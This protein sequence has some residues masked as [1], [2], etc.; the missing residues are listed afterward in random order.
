MVGCE[1]VEIAGRDDAAVG[2]VADEDL[3]TLREAGHESAEVVELA[4][5]AGAEAVVDEEGNLG[6]VGGNGSEGG[7]GGVAVVDFE[8]DVGGCE[9]DWAF[10]AVGD[11]G[12]SRCWC[13]LGLGR[14][15][16]ESQGK[17]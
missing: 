7:D 15:C 8:G 17:E 16:G 13:F 6:L 12:L 11:E 1:A 3:S 2:H 9:G 5:D 10:G 14:A 4:S